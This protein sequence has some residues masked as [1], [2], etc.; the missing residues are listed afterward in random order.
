M[1]RAACSVIQLPVQLSREK[2]QAPPLGTQIVDDIATRAT[3]TPSPIRINSDPQFVPTP[4]RR[5]NEG[6]GRCSPPLEVDSRANRQGPNHPGPLVRLTLAD[7][8]LQR[9]CCININTRIA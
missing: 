5:G 4:S 8:L 1:I 6:I 7:T 3:P 2:Q 9:I